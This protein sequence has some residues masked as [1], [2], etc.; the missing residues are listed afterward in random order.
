MKV[1][2]ILLFPCLLLSACATR[3]DMTYV[4]GEVSRLKQDSET[5]KTQSAGSYS[6]IT[7]YREEI[8]S[9]KGGLEELRH[10][11]S[12]SRKRFDVE[13]SLLVRKSDAIEARLARIEQY[14]GLTEAQGTEK[15]PKAI[16]AADTTKGKPAAAASPAKEVKP[17]APAATGDALLDEGLA[18]LKK[19]DN[20]G[21]RD[22][23]TAFMTRNPK[24]PK[25]ADAQFFIAE[26]Y[27]NEKW[28]EKAILEYQVVI[29]RY[30]KS[31][32]RA[33]A[34]YK[35]ALAFE[36][37]GDSANAKARFKDVVSV[38]PNAPEAKLSKKKL[39]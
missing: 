22:S 23:F 15:S 6:E 39:Q 9:V 19:S 29:A 35:Q 27:F 13:D 28:Y 32:R 33:T 5:I 30:T 2:K 36:K 31:P 38:Y 17:A 25:V 37:I 12:A 3:S 11:Y 16:A 8:A 26:T 4:Q 7:Q 24:S 34:L 18:K 14:L 1:R 20:A 10:D 21:A